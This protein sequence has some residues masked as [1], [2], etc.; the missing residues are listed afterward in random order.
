MDFGSDSLSRQECWIYSTRPAWDYLRIMNGARGAGPLFVFP[1]K[2]RVGP[3]A[4]EASRLL[5][6]S[7]K[8]REKRHRSRVTIYLEPRQISGA[9]VIA[10]AH[11]GNQNGA[12]P[13]TGTCRRPTSSQPATAR[14]RADRHRRPLWPIQSMLGMP[15]VDETLACPQTP[16]VG[17]PYSRP[18]SNRVRCLPL[19]NRHAILG[20]ERK[21]GNTPTRYAPSQPHTALPRAQTP[22][23]RPTVEKPAAHLPN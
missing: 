2:H 21:L 5:R 18:F 3:S 17:F 9:A 11:I 14:C 8:L 6:G 20:D 16:M 22:S 12:Y 19:P 4:R 1:T 23:R 13:V 7:Q 10:R 15:Q